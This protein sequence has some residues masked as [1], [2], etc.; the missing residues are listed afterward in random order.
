MT[1][2]VDAGCKIAG[3]D[4]LTKENPLHSIDKIKLNAGDTVLFKR[5]TVIRTPLFLQSGESGKPITYGA[6]GE[7]ANPVV[8]TSV[9]ACD[10]EQWQEEYPNIWRFTGELPSE[11]CNIV[12]DDGICFGN[13]RWEMESLK[14]QGE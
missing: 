9:Q 1:Y 13:L 2:Y 3:N 12:F 14:K 5:G 6:Y 8:N 10:S 4:G 11:I 7:G